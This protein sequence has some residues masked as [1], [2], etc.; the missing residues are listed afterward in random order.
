VARL[1]RDRTALGFLALAAAGALLLAGVLVAVLLPRGK[2][3]AAPTTSTEQSQP[4]S[5]T[6]STERSQPRSTTVLPPP[7]T[8]A[9]PAS[10]GP[11]RVSATGPFSATVD[12][13]G[14]NAP[15]RVGYGLPDLGPT[16]WA[17]LQGGRAELTGLR[18]G[19]AYRVWA[20]DA[21]A[22]LTTAP[23]PDSPTAG[24]AGG[25][26]QL[27]NQPFF[28]LLVIAQCGENFDAGLQAGATV[29]I[30]NGCSGIAPQTSA[31]AGR[32]LSLTS[33]DQAGIGG[34][35][36]IGWYYPDEPDL[37]GI[38]GDGLPHFPTL[39]E[40]GRL[41]VLTLSN[42][43][44][45][46]TDALPAG[47]GVYPGLVGPSD[48]VGFDL[49]PL[50]E[51]CK[52]DWLPDVATAQRELRALAG[53]R[54]T[55]QWI[56]ARTWQCHQPDLAVTPDTVRAESW[57]ALAG[58]ARGLGF[59]PADWPPEVAPGIA[60]VSKEIAALGPALLAPDQPVSATPPVVAGARS[61]GGAFYVFGVNPTHRSVHATIRAP[62]LHGASA[63]VLGENRS[64][65]ITDG[66]ISD[67]FGPLAVHL[68]VAPPA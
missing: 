4:R 5:T 1:R 39:A 52:V 28:P 47:R 40:T 36:V 10:S 55:F 34:P 27:D 66:A 38:S 57:L 46:R 29:F 17:P 54:P 19:T 15:A 13:V 56:E 65:P 32:A 41:R 67:D 33:A 24:V 12:W 51:S 48:L 11:L 16:L 14:P 45:S 7:P 8:V 42:H 49:Y 23:A 50:Q 22:D 58:G 25:A 43:F 68:Y 61:H 53:D 59:F 9:P 2:N 31:L 35:G 18:F 63:V 64:V 20:G 60:T 62:G 21:T 37:K 3:E 44:Y 6:T 26:V 30:E